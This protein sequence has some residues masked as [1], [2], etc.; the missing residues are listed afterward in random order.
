MK[1]LLIF[2]RKEFYHILR[3][4]KSML[5]LIGM[6]IIQMLIFGFAITNEIRNSNI[7][8]LDNAKDPATQAIIT[9]IE[10]SRYFD[11]ERSL[12]T[13]EQIEKAFRQGKIKMAII[14]PPD[15][16]SDLLHANKAQVQL[17]ADATD[18]NFANTLINYTSSILQDYQAEMNQPGKPRQQISP[19]IRMLYNPELSGTFTSVPGVMALILLLI[20]AMM[21]SIAIVKEREMGT[22]EILLVSPM[23]PWLVVISKTVPY[24]VLSMVNVATI[25]LLSV[26]ALG[27]PI[28]GSLFL[29]I[30]MTI[31]Y[32]LCAL[33]LGLFI[34]TIAKTQQIAMLVS[35]MGLMLPVM[36]LSG[37]VFPIANMPTILQVISNIIPARWFII[38]VKSIMI[39]GLG[40]AAIWKEAFIIL[41]M[42]I[43]FILLSIKRFKVRLQ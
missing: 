17:I 5:V 21:T 26:F 34:S 18:P 8:V 43:F 31:L 1:Q 22:M 11:I 6:P 41:G 29:L 35:L 4:R 37:Y 23:K 19:E 39:K 15:F 30:L 13:N 10:S 14:F 38:I 32:T 42:T 12:V 25:L 33:S 20:S 36:L 7:A 27:L 24:F 2:I 16:G 28:E 3:D 40:F 9:R